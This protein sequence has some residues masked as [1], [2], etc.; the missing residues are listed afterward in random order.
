M[1][2]IQLRGDVEGFGT[3]FLEAGLFRKASVGTSS[4]GIVEAILDGKTG[5]LAPPGNI[6]ALKEAMQ[7][8]LD[9][10]AQRRR[11]GQAA[12]ERVSRY[13]TVHNTATRLAELIA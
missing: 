10:P 12:F 7:R 1:A 8:L 5:L 9:D 13:F 2:S 4:G 6:P 11:L 3:V